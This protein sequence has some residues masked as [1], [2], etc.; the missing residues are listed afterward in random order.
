MNDGDITS[1]RPLTERDARRQVERSLHA[2]E[3]LFGLLVNGVR[4]YSIY[5]IDADGTI[6]TWNTG[7]SR[8]KGYEA[9][10]IIGKPYEKFFTEEDVAAGKPGRMLQEAADKGVVH[11]EGWRVRKDGSRFWASA[12]LTALF[13]ENGILRGFAKVTRDETAKHAA[14][15][16]LQQALERARSAEAGL[17][18]YATELESRVEERTALLSR[19]AEALKRTNTELEQF[20]YIASHDLK[21][22]LRM[23]TGYLELMR[24]RYADRFDEQA[25]GYFHIVIN[26]ASRMHDLVE[27]VLE[28]SRADGGID[29]LEV[30]PLGEAVE[31]ALTSLHSAIEESGATVRVGALPTV[32]ANRLHLAR[33]FQNLLANALKFRSDQPPRITITAEGRDREWEIAVADNGIGI[34]PGMQPRL[35]QIFQRLHTQ[36]AYPGTGIGLAS[37]K[38]IIDLHGGRIWVE[39][40]PGEGSTFTFT[41]K[42]EA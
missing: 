40:S 22:P 13:N 38:K 30:V 4:D 39:S 15:V 10:E 20:A 17:K 36:D 5:V 35:F 3:Q 19:Q 33:V 23:I 26:S 41:L 32:R 29:V 24:K 7:A 31:T 37:C 8:I 34:E 18:E 11:D 16:E 9:D 6:V 21:E 12:T 2:S 1:D 25:R 27:S 28:Y 42:R 14:A